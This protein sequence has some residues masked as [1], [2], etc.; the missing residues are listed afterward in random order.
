M[1]LDA[2]LNVFNFDWISL[3]CLGGDLN[4]FNFEWIH[5]VSDGVG[6]TRIRS[7]QTRK[8]NPFKVEFKSLGKPLSVY[9]I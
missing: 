6:G 4:W 8:A 5:C 7:D 1:F 3:A 2:H 9:A